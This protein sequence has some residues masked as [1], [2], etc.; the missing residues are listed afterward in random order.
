MMTVLV[1][2]TVRPCEPQT[3]TWYA[4]VKSLREWR[5]QS[6]TNQSTHQ[7]ASPTPAEVMAS[8]VGS[9]TKTHLAVRE[10]PVVQDLQQHVPHLRV[11]LCAL[12]RSREQATKQRVSLCSRNARV[13]MRFGRNGTIEHAGIRNDDNATPGDKSQGTLHE[14]AAKQARTRTLGVAK[15]TLLFTFSTSS[16]RT[17]E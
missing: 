15:P 12:P 9:G 5:R 6:I 8:Q 1:K 10:A 3:R 11:R 7:P 17:T 4:H 2:S 13:A 16:K 14:A